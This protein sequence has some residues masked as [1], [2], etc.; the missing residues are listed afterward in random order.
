MR[1]DARAQPSGGNSSQS[2]AVPSTNT[3]LRAAAS[4]IMGNDGIII[5]VIMGNK[6]GIP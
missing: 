2:L 4:I 3:S 5:I 1:V 6:A